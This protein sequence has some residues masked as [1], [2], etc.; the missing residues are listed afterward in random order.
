MSEWCD[1]CWCVH[2][3]LCDIQSLAVVASSAA[4]ADRVITVVAVV[5]AAKPTLVLVVAVVKSVVCNGAV[6]N[7]LLEALFIGIVV[8]IS[9]G[10]MVGR[11]ADTR[12][13]MDI[14][15]AAV[16]IFALYFVVRSPYHTEMLS[17]VVVDALISTLASVDI[18]IAV[19]PG[20]AAGVL[21]GGSANVWASVV[22]ALT[23]AVPTPS[24]ESNR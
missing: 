21:V 15:V 12:A 7:A 5:A 2:C 24:N 14:I 18:S 16:V 23:F 22:T 4:A 8:E 10:A 13:G 9:H 17:G 1:V 6:V 19:V 20:I 11:G 3:V